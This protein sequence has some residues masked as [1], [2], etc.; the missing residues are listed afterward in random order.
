MAISYKKLK[1]QHLTMKLSWQPGL[2]HTEAFIMQSAGLFW[3]QL[4]VVWLNQNKYW[5]F[6]KLKI[7]NLASGLVLALGVYYN[8]IL[9]NLTKSTKIINKNYT[10][11]QFNILMYTLCIVCGIQNLSKSHSPPTPDINILGRAKRRQSLPEDASSPFLQ[12]KKMIIA[13]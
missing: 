3:V 8:T 11:Q 13:N 5:N 6:E 4:E 9:Q 2:I 1:L 12:V 10:L 7:A